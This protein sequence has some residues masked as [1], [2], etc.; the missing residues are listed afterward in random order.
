MMRFLLTRYTHPASESLISEHI[1]AGEPLTGGSAPVRT[2]YASGLFCVYA[3]AA[4]RT[5]FLKAHISSGGDDDSPQAALM[6]R[7]FA[8]QR[9]GRHADATGDPAGANS[10]FPDIGYGRGSSWIH[11]ALSFAWE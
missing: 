10:H 8:Y 11:S 2:G 1:H 5:C 9:D 6:S 3:D 7:R 4:C